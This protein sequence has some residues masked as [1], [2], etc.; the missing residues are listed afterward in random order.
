V[1]EVLE[2]IKMGDMAKDICG[3]EGEVIDV[4]YHEDGNVFRYILMEYDE[5]NGCVKAQWPAHPD[6]TIK[7]N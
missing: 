7:L 1:N 5:E 3:D 2:E 6:Y 4:E